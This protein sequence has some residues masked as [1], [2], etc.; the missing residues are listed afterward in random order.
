MYLLFNIACG[1]GTIPEEWSKSILVL[2]PKKGDL[3]QCVN[4]R[5]VFLINHTGK[6]LLIVLL[7]R[8][9]Q[10]LEPHLSEEQAGFG[11]D[12]STVHQTLTLRLIAEKAKRLGKKICNCFIDFQKAFDTV[13]HKVIWTVLRSY[14][15]EEKM[16]T[17]LQKIYEKAQSA[18]RIGKN[19][20]EWFHAD[21]GTRQGDPLSPLL[22]ITYLERVMDHTKESNYGI[23]LGGTLV[24]NLRFADDIDLINEDFKSLQEQLEKTRAAAAQARLIINVEKTKT[25]VLGDR[26]IEQEIQ[27]GVK[28]SK[29]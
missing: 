23:R 2:K 16:V 24:N 25:M 17:L 29:T 8:L 11:K 10:Q 1:E 7:N 19:Q 14:G 6:S 5:A 15:M 18:V 13:K 26:K 21:L 22:F 12:R 27:I 20:G 28:N 9:K 4:C 3:S